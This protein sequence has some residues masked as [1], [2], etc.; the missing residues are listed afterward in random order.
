[1]PKVYADLAGRGFWGKYILRW[2]R[3]NGDAFALPLASPYPE[4]GAMAELQQPF[5]A[6][7]RSLW[8]ALQ[9][10]TMGQKDWVPG[11]LNYFV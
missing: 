5:C 6:H 11:D 8:K 2:N 3:I 10:K 9:I 4:S 7:G 1:M